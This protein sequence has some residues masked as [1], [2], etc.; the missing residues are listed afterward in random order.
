MFL[1]F[2]SVPSSLRSELNA[3]HRAGYF[4]T[5]LIKKST[6]ICST[7]WLLFIHAEKINK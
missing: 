3:M 1:F 7:M 6:S 4:V 5:E 2:K